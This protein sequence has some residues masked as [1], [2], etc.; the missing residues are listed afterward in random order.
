MSGKEIYLD[1]PLHSYSHHPGLLDGAPVLRANSNDTQNPH[2]GSGRNAAE[3]R[4]P[5]GHDGE[6]N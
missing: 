5:E 1:A 4:P 2:S 6:D 3:A